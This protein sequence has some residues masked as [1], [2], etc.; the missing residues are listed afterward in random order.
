MSREGSGS[1]PSDALRSRLQQNLNTIGC[2]VIEAQSPN[3]DLELL[4]IPFDQT[5][6]MPGHVLRAM[7]LVG[8]NSLNCLR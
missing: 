4:I 7:V 8:L 6:Y 2:N 1:A 3:S 5:L